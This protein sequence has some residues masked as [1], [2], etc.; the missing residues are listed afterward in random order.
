VKFGD[1]S[2]RQ[3]SREADVGAYLVADPQPLEL[4]EPGEGPLDDPADAAQ[5]RAVGCA[6]AGDLRCDVT[7]SQEVAVLVVVIPAVGD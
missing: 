5:A 4:R 7:G 1:V 3:C 6:L 2:G